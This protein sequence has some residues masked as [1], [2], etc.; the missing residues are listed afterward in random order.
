M[1]RSYKEKLFA[2]NNLAFS[3]SQENQELA[4]ELERVRK[5]LVDTKNQCASLEARCKT[6]DENCN[7]LVE[8][9][10]SFAEKYEP[11]FGLYDELK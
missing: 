1:A 5:E 7:K 3:L 6:A 11:D 9:V 10:V 4:R 8:M 2:S